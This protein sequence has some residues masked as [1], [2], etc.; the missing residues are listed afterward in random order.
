MNFLFFGDSMSWQETF[1]VFGLDPA[2]TARYLDINSDGWVSYS[3]IGDFGVSL[4]FSSSKNNG[5]EGIGINYVNPFQKRALKI[6]EKEGFIGI[7]DGHYSSSSECKVYRRG[8]E[9]SYEIRL[10]KTVTLPIS[11]GQKIVKTPVDTL[12]VKTWSIKNS[13]YAQT[14]T[15]ILES[16]NNANHQKPNTIPMVGITTPQNIQ[17]IKIREPIATYNDLPEL[18]GDNS[19]NERKQV[20]EKLTAQVFNNWASLA[21][22]GLF[23]LSMIPMDHHHNEIR[24]MYRC[25]GGELRHGLGGPSNAGFLNVKGVDSCIVRDMEHVQKKDQILLSY[26]YKVGNV[27]AQPPIDRF[28][29][30]VG[31]ALSS[32]LLMSGNVGTKLGLETPLIIENLKRNLKSAYSAFYGTKCPMKFEIPKTLISDIRSFDRDGYCIRG[33]PIN[34]VIDHFFVTYFIQTIKDKYN[35]DSKR[36]IDDFSRASRLS[37][38]DTI[39]ILHNLRGIPVSERFI[40][41]IFREISKVAARSPKTARYFV[42]DIYIERPA[43]ESA[44]EEFLNRVHGSVTIE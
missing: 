14:E 21:A 23:Q 10:P 11:M 15:N 22:N 39:W 18:I 6:L 44:V 38:E 25:G 29:V 12:V 40:P 19:Y 42:N 24:W 34:R 35:I 8:K 32:I 1:G 13:G 37:V 7:V 43:T 9:R 2:D 36:I 5:N 31:T 16:V 4:G 27:V 33:G 20:F 41:R 30:A 3:P 26:D 17:L 28:S